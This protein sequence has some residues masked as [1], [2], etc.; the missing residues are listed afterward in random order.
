MPKHLFDFFYL[1]GK[2][3]WPSL[4]QHQRGLGVV[5]GG[6]SCRIKEVLQCKSAN[7]TVARFSQYHT[8]SIQRKAADGAYA[9]EG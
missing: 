6:F 4:L 1:E 7:S 3:P 5:V 2:Q 8:Q 9:L